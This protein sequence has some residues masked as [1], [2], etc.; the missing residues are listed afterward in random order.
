MEKNILDT[1]ISAE[2]TEYRRIAILIEIL[3]L[4]L[5]FIYST[6]KQSSILI[7]LTP[8]IM[9]IVYLLFGWYIFK[10]KK[11]SLAQISTTIL[12][13]L[14]LSFVGVTHLF[15]IQR[16]GG[17]LDMSIIGLI[18]GA[19]IALFL[20]I[21]YSTK[22]NEALEYRYSLKLLSRVLIFL[23]ILAYWIINM[24]R[25]YAIN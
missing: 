25:P 9:G 2:K 6:I 24:W 11:N 8:S 3:P 20:L 7:I 17:G 18:V 13:G 21:R 10:G 22:K 12:A 1:E 4:I 23:L 5:I 16:W 15:F 14:Y 19:V